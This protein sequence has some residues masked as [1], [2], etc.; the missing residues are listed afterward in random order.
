[1]EAADPRTAEGG[2]ALPVAV[3]S[4]S[5]PWV[6]PVPTPIEGPL[7]SWRLLRLYTRNVLQAWPARAYDEDFVVQSMLGRLILLINAPA[8]IRRVLV[9]NADNYGRTRPTLRIVRPLMGDGLFLAEG[10]R[11]R[12]QRRVTAPAF[13]PRAVPLLACASAA[14]L[15]AAMPRLCAAAE[16][17][18]DLL[19]WFQHLALDVA[20]R[21]MFS[22]PMAAHA[23]A[24]RRVIQRYGSGYSSPGYGDYVLPPWLPSPGDIGRWLLSRPWLRS[25][26]GLIADRR[27]LPR[28]E[29]PADLFDF[30]AAARDPETG[31]GFSEREIRDQVATLILAGHE[32]TAVALFWACTLL[33]AA[34][35]WQQRIAD[36]AAGL[37]LSESGAA[38][39]LPRLATARAVFDEALRLYPPAYV[40][41]RQ[42]RGP[43][44]L[45]GQRVEAGHVVMIAPWVLHRHRRLWHRPAA[46]D[47]SRF[48]SG[49]PPV[50]RFAF[51]PFGAGPRICVG[52]ALALAEG[53]LALATL[54][55][56][57]HIARA[58]DRPVTP[59][60][61][62]TTQP[63]APAPFLLTP[64]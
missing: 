25:I 44:W 49:A 33:A 39:A 26:E 9:D 41:V 35:A 16:E 19:A 58:D 48:L 60:G 8:A 4:E 38:L 55:R 14:G 63:D 13:A 15:A 6:P 45:A 36:E 27:R 40:I 24:I 43:D 17:P 23:A 53:T 34:P 57:F 50:D 56:A 62:V 1:M 11:W 20:G 42:A 59:V 3:A 64:R 46:F 47:P 32:T 21:A 5:E 2:I 12:R 30:L 29:Q 51:L 7:S 18:I 31:E 52:A 37:D 61:I 28:K 54:T 10:A 22:L